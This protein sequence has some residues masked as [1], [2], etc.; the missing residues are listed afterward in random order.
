VNS[1]LRGDT[2]HSLRLASGI[3]LFGFTLLHLVN[4]ALGL[5][6]LD[7]MLAVQ[8]W[9]VLVTRSWPG[10]VLLGG[11]LVVH[12]ALSA[13]KISRR[14]T[15][16][17][18]PTEAFL[19]GLGLLI[20]FLLLPHIIDTHGAA[21]L[22]GIRDTYLYVLARTWPSAALTQTLL[23]AMV[24]VHGCAGIRSWLAADPRFKHY[25]TLLLVV[26]AILPLA[27][28][29]GYLSDT[30]PLGIAI[31][32]MATGAYLLVIVS[33]LTLPETKGCELTS[34]I[35]PVPTM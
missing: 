29:V 5:I 27:A 35:D 21:S 13:A 9:R 17:M 12:I 22:L 10:M 26:A 16:R 34:T 6:S 7:A 33:V 32:Y 8:Y 24:W 11:S 2:A 25:E 30:M 28:L 20:P 23:V 14:T 1:L 19:T 18:E 15:W 4:H 31:G 3:V